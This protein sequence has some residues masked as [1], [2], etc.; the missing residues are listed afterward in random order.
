VV[1]VVGNKRP[2]NEPGRR[3][4]ISSGVSSDRRGVARPGWPG[5]CTR[6]PGGGMRWRMRERHGGPD[7]MAS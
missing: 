7:A 3:A 2:R 6:F 4:G 5:C 1:S